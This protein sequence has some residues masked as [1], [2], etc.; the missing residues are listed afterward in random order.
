MT[1]KNKYENPTSIKGLISNLHTAGLDKTE[2]V[3]N[4][5]PECDKMTNNCIECK[6]LDY[7]IELEN[8]Q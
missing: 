6:N 1:H 4:D 2:P 3:E 8:S 7:C 5:W